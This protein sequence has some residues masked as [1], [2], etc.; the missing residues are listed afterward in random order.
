MCQIWRRAIYTSPR[1][2]RLR[3]FY[4]HGRPV[5]KTPDCW[6]TLPV[7]VQYGG[8]P[9]LGL[10]AS[11]AEDNVVA[12]LKQSGRVCSINLVITRPLLER[13]STISEPF[14]ELEELVLLSQKDVQL[15]LPNTFRWGS[16]LRTLYLT[17]IA[18]P[19]FPQIVLPSKGLVDLY[20]IPILGY[21]F[22]E[23]FADALSG[24]TQLRSLSLHFLSRPPRNDFGLPSQSGQRILLPSLAIL[25]YRGTSKYLDSLVTR[26]DA[27]CLGDVDITF[28]SQLIM[29][30]SQL[31]QFIERIE[32]LKSHSQADILISERAI[33][34]RFL[35]PRAPTS[36]GLQV[37]GAQLDRQLSS[38]G[39]ICNHFSPFLFRVKDLRVS[40]TRPSSGWDDVDGRRYLELIGAFGGATY[41]RVTGE[42]TTDILCALSPVDGECTTILFFPAQ[43]LCTGTL[44]GAW[45]VVGSRTVIHHFAMAAQ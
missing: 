36:L 10:L 19:S 29:D 17:R 43:L 9:R 25:K 8:S 39:Q 34:I 3:L 28:F 20:E 13:F 33:S 27:P 4:K 42:L 32:I 2:L 12:A 5:L 1:S 35:Q 21:F 44:V 14:S 16:R 7:V 26:I 37:S 40:S 22:P 15:T 24:M 6:P 41:F 18:F 11:A 31:G 30:A 45:A 38:M 23:Q